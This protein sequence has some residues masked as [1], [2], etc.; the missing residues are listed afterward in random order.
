MTSRVNMEKEKVVLFNLLRKKLRET[1]YSDIIC[2]NIELSF[3]IPRNFGWITKDTKLYTRSIVKNV[4]SDI[5]QPFSLQHLSAAKSISFLNK[6]NCIILCGVYNAVKNKRLYIRVGED[7]KRRQL[8]FCVI[9]KELIDLKM[10]KSSVELQCFEY[11]NPNP[12]C[13]RCGIINRIEFEVCM[14]TFCI[15]LKN[16]LLYTQTVEQRWHTKECEDNE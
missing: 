8:N 5:L 9:V 13:S 12:I 11:K 6:Y 10:M 2:T 16:A 1:E 7:Y 3:N 15:F 4:K 14:C